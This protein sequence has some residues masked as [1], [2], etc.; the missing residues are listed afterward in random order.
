MALDRCLTAL[1]NGLPAQHVFLS[2]G[3]RNAALIRNFISSNYHCY[4][5]V[6]ERSAAFKALGIARALGEAVVLNCTSGTAALNYYPAIAEAFYSRI[7]LIVITA[8]R[9]SK[10]IDQWDGKAIRQQGDFDQQIRK[11]WNCPE[12]L[13]ESAF[14]TICNEVNAYFE[15]GIL[16]PVH[17]NVP[18]AEPFYEPSSESVQAEIR[19]VKTLPKRKSISTAQIRSHFQIDPNKKVLFFNGHA[20]LQEPIIEASNDSEVLLSDVGSR[21]KDSIEYWD[22][23]LFLNLKN[24]EKIRDLKPDVLISAGTGTVSKGLKLFLRKYPPTKHIHLSNFKEVGNMFRS[25]MEVRALP[26]D[27]VEE[28]EVHKQYFSL[29]TDKAASI[30]QKFQDLNW[31]DFHEFAL[32]KEIMDRLPWPSVVHLGNSMPVRYVSYLKKKNTAYPFY[33]N[34]GTSGIDGSLSAAVGHAMAV[35]EDVYVIIGDQSFFYDINALWQDQLPLNL[36]IIVLNNGGGQIFNYLQGPA[37]FKE[38][39]KFQTTEHSR[40]A[41]RICDHFGIEYFCARNFEEFEQNWTVF[42]NNLGPILLEIK[43]NPDLNLR[44]YQAFKNAIDE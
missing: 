11:S 35:E 9:P 12:I 38:A 40:E 20:A 4:S 8:D 15:T 1:L 28:V 29:C 43:T 30:K 5:A 31:T 23:F 22:A 42:A 6:D 25:N 7:P 32:V 33:A 44:E 24:I 3:S 13:N 37:R 18:I 16:G 17:I 21:G 27:E 10:D 36:K 19:K 39:L 2:P 34:R 41:S 26:S 14:K